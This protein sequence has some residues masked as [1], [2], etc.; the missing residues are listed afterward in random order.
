MVTIDNKAKSIG[1]KYARQYKHNNCDI[2][3]NKEFVFSNEEIAEGC[4]EMAEYV[5]ERAC[6]YFRP[7]IPDNSG[8]YDRVRVIEDFIYQITGKI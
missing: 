2:A 8:G 1:K 3:D 4:K 6:D 7:Y 5:I